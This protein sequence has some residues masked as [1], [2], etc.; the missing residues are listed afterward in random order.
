MGRGFSGWR[1]ASPTL[2]DTSRDWD[3][4]L[5]WMGAFQELADGA[6]SQAPGERNATS[7][8]IEE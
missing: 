3:L 6:G 1:R 2:T 8:D 4:L 7:V 5:A